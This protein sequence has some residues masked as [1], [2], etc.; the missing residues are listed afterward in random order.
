MIKLPPD[1]DDDT[2]LVPSR[3][4]GKPG[5]R[6]VWATAAY[7]DSEYGLMLG[8]TQGESQSAAIF[9][10]ESRFAAFRRLLPQ[11]YRG[12]FKDAARLPQFKLRMAGLKGVNR[13]W[14]RSRRRSR[15]GRSRDRN[16]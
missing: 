10:A 13:R 16:G 7:Q 11:K 2:R 6:G 12:V 3:A 1:S 5:T 9:I 8:V 14:S 15:F 4:L